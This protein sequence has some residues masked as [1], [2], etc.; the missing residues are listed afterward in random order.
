MGDGSQDRQTEDHE[1]DHSCKYLCE[2]VPAREPAPQFFRGCIGQEIGHQ[3]QNDDNQD[4]RQNPEQE[5]IA[6]FEQI[7]DP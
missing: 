4:R 5:G 2:P 1:K 7:L 6:E 3:S